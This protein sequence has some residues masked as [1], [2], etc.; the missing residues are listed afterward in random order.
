MLMNKDICYKA[1]VSHDARF[2]GVF[3]TCVRTTGIYCRPVCPTPPPK[4]QNCSFVASAALAEKA[5]YRP[6]LR[7]RPELSPLAQL[8][9]NSPAHML[10]RHIEET[11]LMDE[12]LSGVATNYG[13]SERQ[14]RRTF[15]ETVGVTPKEYVM[16]R[17]LLFA[18]QLLQETALPIIDVAYSSGFNT[19]GRLTIA[20]RE[21]YG[22]TPSQLRKQVSNSA[23]GML[24]LRA[25]YRPSFDWNALLHVLAGRSTPAE[26]IADD[27]YH[28]IMQDKVIRVAHDAHNNQVLVTIPAEL[29][30]QSHVIMQSVRRLF[31]LDANPIAI[32]EALS[33]DPRM[34]TLMQQYPGVRV[35]GAWDA[36]ELL[37]RVIVGQQISV[38]GATTIMRRIVERIGATPDLLA[39]ATPPTIAQAGMPLKRAATIH[40]V[41]TR[42]RDGSVDLTER[43]PERFY[44]QLVAVPGIGPW[45]AEYLCMRLLHW[46][47][48]FPAGDLG[49]QKALGMPGMRLTESAARAA[50]QTWRPWRSYATMLL[51]RSISNQGG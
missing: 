27:A 48:A 25:S 7:C 44:Q 22:L 12:T 41:S 20:M 1:L 40:A 18:K 39:G 6:C 34:A 5:G 9:E 31:D 32:A 17:R 29:S 46:P 16:T 14:L 30:R 4:P 38:A 33:A 13:M 49:I 35:P 8:T 21:A 19:P 47:D 23:E 42:V 37:I 43:N 51:W 3:F 2:D 50:S 36:F 15:S 10:R 28:R 26:Y 24:V 11:L 45:T